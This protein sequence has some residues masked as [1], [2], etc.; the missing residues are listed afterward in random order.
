[1]AW[2]G[3]GASWAAGFSGSVGPGD[4]EWPPS[5]AWPYCW[6]SGR[7]SAQPRPCVHTVP[8]M[9]RGGHKVNRVKM[10]TKVSDIQGDQVRD[11]HAIAGGPAGWR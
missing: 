5:W 9:A 3:G 2:A 10:G 1:M 8:G 4:R 6:H 7:S 11:T